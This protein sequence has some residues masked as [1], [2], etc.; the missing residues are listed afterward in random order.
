MCS[1]GKDLKG[2]VD[3]LDLRIREREKSSSPGILT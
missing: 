3:G 1:G 2:L